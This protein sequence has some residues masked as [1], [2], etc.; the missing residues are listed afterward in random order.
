MRPEEFIGRLSG[1]KQ[2]GVREWMADC[3][4]APADDHHWL[5][6]RPG[7]V[8]N[9]I[10]TCCGGCT[11]DHI[12]SAMGLPLLALIENGFGKSDAD[13]TPKWRP[14]LVLFALQPEVAHVHH[15][16]EGMKSGRA[17]S[18]SDFRR[19]TLAQDRIGNALRLIQVLDIREVTGVA[20]EVND[21][22]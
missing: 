17:L 19:L 21:A 5:P 12:L 6:I 7:E 15:H 11:T 18:A 20:S 9:T 1:A 14:E 4:A 8:G 3:P 22:H 2:V 10:V 13:G 16:A